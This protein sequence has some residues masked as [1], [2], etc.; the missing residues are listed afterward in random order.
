MA[1]VEEARNCSGVV[2]RSL[3]TVFSG[4]GE[5]ERQ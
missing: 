1:R 5:P 4:F 3:Q 2:P